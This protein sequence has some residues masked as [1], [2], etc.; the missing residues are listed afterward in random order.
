MK[1]LKRLTSINDWTSLEENIVTKGQSIFMIPTKTVPIK[2]LIRYADNKYS[3]RDFKTNTFPEHLSFSNKQD[4]YEYLKT[5]YEKQIEEVVKLTQLEEQIQFTSW[6]DFNSL[7]QKDWTKITQRLHY[8]NKKLIIVSWVSGSGKSTWIREN[9]FQNFTLSMDQIRL[10]YTQTQLDLDWFEHIDQES[11]GK[12]IDLFYQLLTDRMKKGLMTVVDSTNLSTS[13]YHRYQSLAA[14][15]WYELLYKKFDITLEEALQRN[16]N[17]LTNWEAFRYVYPEV[18]TEQYRLLQL[19]Q[20]PKW[21]KEITDSSTL[22]NKITNYIDWNKYE[23][24]YY[25]GDIQGCPKELQEFLDKYY[26]DK[27]LYIFTWDLLDRGYDNKWVLDIILTLVDK[28]NIHFIEGNHDTYL[29]KYVEGIFP[30]WKNEFD[31]RTYPQIKE[32]TLTALKRITTKFK[33]SVSIEVWNKRI[34]ATHWWLPR[35]VDFIESKSCIRGVWDY[36]EHSIC[37]SNFEKWS[38]SEEKRTG[39]QYYSVHWHRNVHE[40]S[41]KVN[42]RVYNLEGKVEFNGEFRCCKFTKDSDEPI[43]IKALWFSKRKEG[44]IDWETLKDK[45]IDH[46]LV[47]VYPLRDWLYS[48]NFTRDAF[49]NK[50]WDETNIKARWLFIWDNNEIYARSYNKFFNVDERIETRKEN[51]AN[52]LGFP[53]E[54]YHKYNWF[55][56]IT[57]SFNDEVLYCSKSRIEWEFPS[58]VRELLQ[59]Y[60]DKIKQVQSLLKWRYSLVWEICHRDDPHII[61]ESERPILLDVIKN[62]LNFEKIGFKDLQSIAK[63]IWVECKKH[64]TTLH[65][66]NELMKFLEK[67][68]NDRCE[69][70]V[71]EGP[72]WM[73]KTKTNFYLFWKEI[74]WQIKHYLNWNHQRCWHINFIKNLD[75]I[76]RIDLNLPIIDIIHKFELLDDFRDYIPRREYKEG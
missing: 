1:T 35:V 15:Y 6:S 45:F 42:S 31:T 56:G 22:N 67:A 66:E 12:V 8:P 32:F 34:I 40:D 9:W 30:I 72:N 38:L 53:I 19:L 47:S 59:P 46:P 14:E 43:I 62:D 60:E 68:Q 52:H 27:S 2:I 51:L 73:T 16:E 20:I 4:I 71:L 39:F 76:Y 25:I 29:K 75:L 48:V 11:N 23:A 65:N 64:V 57:W 13:Y 36:S 17:R 49:Y 24:I 21:I 33:T 63:F 7:P 54:V 44:T 10:M 55:L 61:K 69:G 70:Y 5:T 28:E 58:K 18:I 41:I 74:R 3:I 26:N 37:D 50:S